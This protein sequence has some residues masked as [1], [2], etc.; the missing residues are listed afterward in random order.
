MNKT[1]VIALLVGLAAWAFGKAGT[2]A[3]PMLS[4]GT[5]K[6]SS[7]LTYRPYDQSTPVGGG[8]YAWGVDAG[9]AE[10]ISMNNPASYSAGEWG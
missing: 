10:V 5:V 7:G 6:T 1:L 4:S 9:G 2:S 3:T 8:F